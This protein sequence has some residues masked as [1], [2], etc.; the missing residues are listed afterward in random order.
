M[1]KYIFF[2][3]LI[4]F[5]VY[6]SAQT[7]NEVKFF[8]LSDVRLLE[9]PFLQAQ[10][11]D[12]NYILA[13][14]PDRLLSPF[15]REAGLP[16]K[17][18]SYTNWEN[19][20]LDGHIGGHYLSALSMM[21][22]AT[23]NPELKRRLDYMLDELERCQ[24]AVGSGFIGGTPG[25][26]QLWDEIK[27]GNIR[28]ASFGLNDKWV[29]LYNIHKTFNGLLD[30][31]KHTGSRKSLAILIRLSDWMI[32]IT[33]GLTDEQMQDMLRSEHGGLNEVFA[34]LS[35][36]T[37]EN[38]YLNLANRFS[39]KKILDPLIDQKDELTGMH[40]NTQIPKVI[41]FER[42]AEIDHDSNWAKAAEFF[43]Q[44]V[45]QNRSVSIGGNSVREHFNP[46]NDFSS[47]IESVEGPETC[48]SY[49]MLKLTKLLYGRMPETKYMDYYER[50][51]Y[52]H[53]LSTEQ[54]ETGGFVYFTP[55]RPGH[56][57][58]YSQPETS[59]WCCVGSGLENHTK[60][61]EMIYAYRG[62][63]LFVNLFIPSVLNWKEKSVQITQETT[64]PESDEIHLSINKSTRKPFTIYIRKPEWVNDDE[65]SIS[66][67]GVNQQ[68]TA[69]NG[70]IS[71]HRRWKKNDKI[72]VALPMHL[73]L[74]QLPD[75]S[76]FYAFCYGPIVLA[77]P[78]GTEDMK[79][80]YA[81]DSRGGHIA[82][83]TQ[84]ALQEMPAF[85]GEPNE[86]LSNT[87]KENAGGL[88]FAYK[89]KTFPDKSEI[90][91]IPFYRL[92]NQRYFIYF[93]QA[94]EKDLTQLQ[95]EYEA[96]K[97]ELSA[98]TLD[99]VYPGEQQ[100]ESDHGVKYG[101]SET[102][103]LN[104]KHYRKAS[105]FFSYQIKLSEEASE[106]QLLVRENDQNS[107]QVFIDGEKVNAEANKSK[108][109]NGFVRLSYTIPLKKGTHELRFEPNKTPF[110]SEVYE[111]KIIK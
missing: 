16:K 48:N 57:R 111:V 25:S 75:K 88:S 89:G 50:T 47:M 79:G 68:V 73:T 63:E 85:I 44:T 26:L 106:L 65:W 81:D 52:N 55:M 97:K 53:I 107:T 109:K 7:G 8:P 91:F 78:M 92:H 100:P 14:N 83:G 18:E 70:Y 31:Y 17:A 36:I 103:S 6:S 39:H 10:Q 37:H 42:I 33:Q 40:A 24:R 86:I 12:L 19:T 20:G 60:Y 93:K 84:I 101:N 32:N 5:S 102:G 54:P 41:G 96:Y 15:L 28:A 46:V 35:A 99:V 1:R 3:Y 95:Q 49:N 72:S 94:N 34:E 11:A 59:F 22:E 80:L 56:Y 74:D 69:K 104:G 51:L 90:E 29:P 4:L 98:V 21:Y 64:F 108:V 58:V 13:L 71:I 23:G 43:W 9:S 77:S 66:V 105:D 82:H 45:T 87:K 62:N 110:T 67:N 30:A 38:K 76:N 27:H 61:G 2:F